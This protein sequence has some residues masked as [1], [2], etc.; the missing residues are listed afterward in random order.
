[1][2]SGAVNIANNEDNE[3]KR[4]EMSPTFSIINENTNFM[5]KRLLNKKIHN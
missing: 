4:F 5:S 2:H 1:M 3:R